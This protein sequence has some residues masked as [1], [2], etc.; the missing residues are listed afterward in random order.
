MTL[1]DRIAKLEAKLMPTQQE[2]LF[3]LRVFVTPGQV[4]A[5]PEAEFRHLRRGGQSW[6]RR[7]DE[8]ENAFKERA[9]LES[10]HSHGPQVFVVNPISTAQ[11]GKVSTSAQ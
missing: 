4:E 6:T 1:E 3:I 2:P 8:S 10:I 7:E 9:I 5:T 11:F